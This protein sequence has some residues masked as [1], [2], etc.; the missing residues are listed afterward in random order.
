MIML[1]HILIIAIILEVPEHA[2]R[3]HAEPELLRDPG[4]ARARVGPRR[5]GAPAIYLSI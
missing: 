2:E 5:H 4:G 3:A 1:V